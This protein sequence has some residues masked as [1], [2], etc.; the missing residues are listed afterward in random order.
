MMRTGAIVRRAQQGDEPEWLRMRLAL[1]P[2]CSKE[3]HESEISA[4]LRDQAQAAA[5]VSER[6]EN[7][8]CGFIEVYIRPF[9]EG[10]RT[11]PVGHIEGWY[12]DRESRWK[13]IGKLL[14]VAAEQ[15]AR[16]KGC[17]EMASDAEVSNLDGEEAH[18]RLG[19]TECSRLVHFKK[20]L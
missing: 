18:R 5:F 3:A 14:V 13:G 16:A 19:Y 20:D 4:L 6:G 8:L 10:C 1:W 11:R 2:H 7:G 9:A 17:K 12:V 15:W